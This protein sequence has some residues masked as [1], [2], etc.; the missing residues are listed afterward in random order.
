MCSP[1]LLKCHASVNLDAPAAT[2]SSLVTAAGGHHDCLSAVRATLLCREAV[3]CVHRLGQAD[4]RAVS[5]SGM[6]WAVS[7]GGGAGSN[8]VF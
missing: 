8:R 4:E 3:R 6:A 2:R 7:A 5:V 1:W